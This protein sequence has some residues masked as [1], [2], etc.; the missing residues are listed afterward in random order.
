MA[1]TPSPCTERAGVSLAP[2]FSYFGGKWRL[3]PRYPR[4]RHET[5]VEPFAGSAGYATRFHWCR[6]ILVEKDPTV[7]GIW[8]WLI[9][10]TARE[11]MALPEDP[12]LLQRGPA[13]AMMELNLNQ[14]SRYVG[15]DRKR[16]GGGTFDGQSG[17]TWCRVIR[18]RI[19][20]QVDKIRHWQV[21]EGDYTQAPDVAATWFID[22]PYEGIDAYRCK[23]AA[24]N[25][26]AL[27]AWCRERR[28]QVIV[29]EQQGATWLPFRPFRASPTA[30]RSRAKPFGRR[31]IC[32]PPAPAL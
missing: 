13:R 29:C 6:V 14:A 3:A 10:A 9:N 2:F 28:G 25:Y 24:I 5:I 17:R 22:P 18:A 31:R 15:Q 21:I 30:A 7:A 12:E 11:I 26:P 19:A 8:R 32:R 16:Y 4:P 20:S 27:G 23:G 1:A